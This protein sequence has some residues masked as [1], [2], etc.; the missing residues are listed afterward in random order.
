MIDVP[1]SRQES[2][3]PLSKS[4]PLLADHYGHPDAQISRLKIFFAFSYLT[5]TNDSIGD[6]IDDVNRTVD[7]S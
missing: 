4:G 5:L 3:L 1:F 6:S 2:A 7:H